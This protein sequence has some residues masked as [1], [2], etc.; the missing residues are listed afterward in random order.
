FSIPGAKLATYILGAMPAFA[1]LTARGLYRLR[2][3]DAALPVFLKRITAAVAVCIAL[4]LVV[5]AFT[6]SHLPPNLHSIVSKSFLP[7]APLCIALAIIFGGG[8][9][10]ALSG[11]V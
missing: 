4:G 9:L 7:V 2:C 1:L 10:L 6:Y 5:L 8:W 11:R 3:G